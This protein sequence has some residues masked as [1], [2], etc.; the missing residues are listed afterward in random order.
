MNDRL[1]IEAAAN[2]A[3]ATP[4][5]G[6]YIGESINFPYADQ[7]DNWID[8]AVSRDTTWATKSVEASEAAAAA[9]AAG[10]NGVSLRFAM[11]WAPDSG[12]NAMT[13]AGAVADCSC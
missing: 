3:R 4:E 11:F 10:A 1:R 5:G 8:E 6:R 13:M 9:A 12:H 7:G 2:L